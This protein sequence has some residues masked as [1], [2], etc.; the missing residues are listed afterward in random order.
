MCWDIVLDNY[1]PVQVT[2]FFCLSTQAQIVVIFNYRKQLLQK[3]L[4]S[5]LVYHF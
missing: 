1:S 5:Y 4:K 2:I 3:R